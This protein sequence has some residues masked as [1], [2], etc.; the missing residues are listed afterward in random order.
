M[1]KIAQMDSSTPARYALH[2]AL[3]EFRRPGG[4]PQKTLPSIMKKQLKKQNEHEL[5]LKRLT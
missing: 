2:C 1:V 3:E 5:D 4:R